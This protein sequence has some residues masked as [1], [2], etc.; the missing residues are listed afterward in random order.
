M[1]SLLT[2]SSPNEGSLV[3]LTLDEPFTDRL[4][5]H[6][7]LQLSVLYY[8][9]R[10]EEFRKV[11]SGFLGILVMISAVGGQED[12]DDPPIQMIQR[13]PPLQMD[14][15]TIKKIYKEIEPHMW[16]SLINVDQES[17]EF[18]GRKK[19]MSRH[20]MSRDNDGTWRSF[21]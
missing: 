15:V 2:E 4:G 10:T 6:Q 21:Q 17:K 12:T 19:N 9:W 20:L 8:R 14:A 3:Q 11:S 16:L 1:Q 5:G 7:C 13:E 18:D